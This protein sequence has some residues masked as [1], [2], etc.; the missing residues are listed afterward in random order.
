MR[1][2]IAILFDK[3]ATCA[4]EEAMEELSAQNIRGNYTRPENLH[5]TLAFLGETEDARGAIGAMTAAA[6]QGFPITLEGIG[7]FGDTLWAGVQS[8]GKLEALAERLKEALSAR[9]FSIERRKFLPHITLVRRAE[10]Q[11][12][13]SRIGLCAPMKV[14]RV[15]L[16][17]SRRVGGKLIY[18]E[19]YGCN[20]SE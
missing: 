13:R 16:M 18:T 10:G 20:L 1:L 6:G 2:F 15:S 8:S 9:G 14:G 5:L 7:R 4:L 3:E 19:L 17:W 12:D 11:E